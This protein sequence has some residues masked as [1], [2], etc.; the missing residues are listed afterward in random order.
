MQELGG[1]DSL[2]KGVRI[3]QSFEVTNRRDDSSFGHDISR[4]YSQNCFTLLAASIEIMY[5]QWIGTLTSR[6]RER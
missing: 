5:E 2:S 1:D 6:C 4:I 3:P